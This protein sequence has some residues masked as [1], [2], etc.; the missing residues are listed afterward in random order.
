MGLYMGEETG[1]SIPFQVPHLCE[2][3]TVLAAALGP[4]N[5]GASGLSP[6][7]STCGEQSREKAHHRKKE[8]GL[9]GQADPSSNADAPEDEKLIVFS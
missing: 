5:I 3:W 6:T 7:P 9:R 2:P 4:T 1:L 8:H